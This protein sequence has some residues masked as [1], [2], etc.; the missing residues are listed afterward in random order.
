ML[1]TQSLASLPRQPWLGLRGRVQHSATVQSPACAAS[2][3][4]RV[5]EERVL[6]RNVGSTLDR[7]RESLA[8]WPP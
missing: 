5:G 4:A 7:G 1:C 3:S 2:M 8:S 6:G